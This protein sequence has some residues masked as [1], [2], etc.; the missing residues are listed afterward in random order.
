MDFDE[1]IIRAFVIAAI[2]AGWM[3]VCAGLVVVAHLLLTLPMR[4]AE[5]ARLFL[6]IIDGALQQGRSPEETIVSVA[7]SRDLSMG[8][9]FHVVAA[10]IESNL[11]MLDAIAK[12]PRFLPP[13]I[14]AM[15]NAGRKI[16]DVRKVLPA[17]RQL[18]RDAVSHTRSAINYLIILTFVVTPMS[19][20]VIWLLQIFVMPRFLE[21]RSA[22]FHANAPVTVATSVLQHGLGLGLLHL[23]VLSLVWIVAFIYFAGPRT[24]LWFPILQYIQMCLPWRRKRL[25]RDFSA[26]LAILLDSGVPEPDAVVLAADC[27]ANNILK[28]RAVRTVEALKRGVALP[29]AIQIMD[30]SGEFG[31]RMANAVHQRTGF[32]QAL[33]GWHAWLDAKAFQQ[34]QAA[35]QTITSGLVLWTGAI[36]AAVVISVFSVLISITNAGLLW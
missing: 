18:L 16:G 25:Q 11:P 33:N 1:T 9:R 26:M 3:G 27:T 14:S 31:W 7:A 8:V 13:Q 34:E 23:A 6:D 21:I 30:G 36:V 22:V 19:I 5:R 2:F 24:A 10:W 17:C 35:A 12:V 32:A 15:L 4:R 29:E 20:W 28:M